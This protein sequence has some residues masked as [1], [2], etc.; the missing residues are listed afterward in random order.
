MPSPFAVRV[1][2]WSDALSFARRV[3]EAVFVIEQAVPKELE[4]D[5]WDERSDHA[6]AFGTGNEAIATGRLLA[7]GRIGRMAVLRAWRGKGVGTAILRALIERARERG[8]A[9]VR[10]HAQT[11]ALGFYRAFGF[12]ERGEVFYEAGI[13]HLEMALD[14]RP[15]PPGETDS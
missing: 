2:S 6:V 15:K 11:H 13:P 1:L 9:L 10:L 3:R 14:L 4:W 7:D 8:I 5:E 12:S